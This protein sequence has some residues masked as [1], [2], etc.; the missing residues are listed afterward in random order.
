M[1]IRHDKISAYHPQSNGLCERFY[2]ALKTSLSLVVNKGKNN[3]DTFVP[4]MVAAYRTTPHSVTRET[5]CF[6]MFG[7][8][9]RVSPS[10]GFQP[11][12]H[13][14]T[15]DFVTERNNSL[16]QDYEIVRDLN[17]KE[18]ESHKTACDQKYKAQRAE[19]KIG[20]S[21]YLKVGERKTGLHRNYWFGPYQ[22]VEL[23]SNENVKLDMP[24]SN[25]HP[26]VNINR[27]KKNKADD[28]AELSKS[29]RTVLD[30]MRKGSIGN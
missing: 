24:N 11:P 14:Y 5:P 23:I 15:E 16:R 18:R 9:F 4:D 12:M 10:V 7:R 21:V 26:I 3:W 20:D 13:S 29:I 27:L 22:V 8:Q 25:R 30:K 19:F 1:K 2:D 6:L 28:P 17:K